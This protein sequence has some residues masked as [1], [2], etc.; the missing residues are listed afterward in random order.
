MDAL[1]IRFSNSSS[2]S[3]IINF[4]DA[5]LRPVQFQPCGPAGSLYSTAHDMARWLQVLLS[6]GKSPD[7]RRV[8]Q[9]SALKETTRAVMPPPGIGT[10]MTK[11]EFP[12]GDVEPVL[13][14]GMGLVQLQG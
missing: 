1:E 13:W 3:I 8:L 2:C 12:I 11:P 10:D 5:L 6:N 9:E 7:G 14:T 4:S